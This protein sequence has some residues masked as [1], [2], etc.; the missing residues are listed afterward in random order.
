MAESFCK[1]AKSLGLFPAHCG[2]GKQQNSFP[3]YPG[4]VANEGTFET[5]LLHRF[6]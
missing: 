2:G 1:M 4:N 6:V 3:V 5:R